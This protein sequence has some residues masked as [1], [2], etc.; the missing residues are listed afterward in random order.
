MPF[1]KFRGVPLS[2]VPTSYLRWALENI[3]LKYGLDG[4]IRHELR[5]RA[6]REAFE[7]SIPM[8][9][10]LQITVALKLVEAGRRTL[11]KAHHPDLG[12]STEAMQTVNQVADALS[13][14]LGSLQEAR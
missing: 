5:N 6:A 8:P 13:E 12:G 3:A 2:E 14:L 7:R 9:K 10:G 4:E 1:G 11:A